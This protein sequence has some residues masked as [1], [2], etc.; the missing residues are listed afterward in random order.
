[1]RALQHKRPFNTGEIAKDAA[2]FKPPGFKQARYRFCLTNAKFDD[3]DPGRPEQ[4]L[5]DFSQ[6][7]ESVKSIGS[8]VKR[9]ARVMVPHF[10]IERRDIRRGDIGRI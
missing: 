7:P 2:W 5:Q 9:Q 10:G 3:R 1:M 4:S 8:A 6:R